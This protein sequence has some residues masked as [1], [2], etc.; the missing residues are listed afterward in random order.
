MLG[1]LAFVIFIN[2]LDICTRLVT[3]MNKFADDTKVGHS[4]QSAD[5]RDILQECID[6]LTDWTNTWSMMFNVQKCKVLHLGIDPPYL[7][8]SCVAFHG[9][10]S[11]TRS[12][13]SVPLL[14]SSY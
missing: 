6:K 8:S 1:T 12:V 4:V 2:D 9:I 5:D 7:S 11:I 13:G 14:E 3:I 10:P